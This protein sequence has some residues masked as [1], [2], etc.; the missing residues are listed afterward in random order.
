MAKLGRW[1]AKSVALLACYGSSLG[2]NPDIAQKYK[3]GDI[4][5][6]S[7]GQHTLSRQKT[8]LEYKL[9]FTLIKGAAF[10]CFSAV[11]KFESRLDIPTEQ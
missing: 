11:P 1:V 10:A 8:Y 3:M 7:G 5:K 4:S 6:T 9:R 2:S